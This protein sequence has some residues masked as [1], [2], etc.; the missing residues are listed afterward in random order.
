MTLIRYS[1]ILMFTGAHCYAQLVH[2][3][4]NDA[5]LQNE[6]ASVYITIAPEDLETILTDSIL[7]DYEYPASFRYVSSLF[8]DSIEQVGF[9]LRGNTSRYSAKKSFKVAFN[10]FISG[11]KW[12]GLEKLNLNG[13]HNDPSIMRSRMSNQLLKYAGVPCSRTSY[14]RLYVNEEYK[15]LYLNAEHIDDEFLQR[16]FIADDEGNLYKCFW[17]ADLTYL[18]PNPLNYSEIYEL[19]TNKIQNDYT[20]LISFIEALNNTSEEEFPCV[21]Q[22]LFDVDLYLRT[23]VMEILIGHWDG[24]AVNKNNFYLYQRPSDG[25]FV[26]I[27]YDMDNTFGIDWDN[28][29]WAIRDVYSWGEVDRP[30]YNRIMDVPYFRDRF[31]FYFQEAQEAIYLPS[32]FITEC[33][34]TQGLIASAA[35]SDTYKELDY[36]FTNEDFMNSIESAFGMHVTTSIEDFVNDRY[37]T[38]L[39]QIDICIGL[40]NPCELGIAEL[41]NTFNPVRFYDVSGREISSLSTFNGVYIGQSISG[42]VKKYYKYE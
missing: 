20:G 8:S 32:D 25:R 15:G 18:G 29:N 41:N 26:F 31:N 23:L 7:S 2:P 9:R 11:Q 3:N 5:F 33:N 39:D 16:R 40:S 21:I 10:S 36:G 17:G 4:N 19:K 12:K 34:E 24:Y 6:V 22:E 30:L 37:D 35:L 27:E 13:E 42:E 14:V 28:V 38:S 1:F